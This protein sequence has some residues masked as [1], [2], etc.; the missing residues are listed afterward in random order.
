MNSR[1]KVLLANLGL[2]LLLY[3][4][5]R[6][7]FLALNFQSYIQ[8][9]LREL[10]LA[11][12][13]GGRF[14]IA[15]ICRINAPFI[16]LSLLPFGFVDKPWYR[17]LLKAVFLIA[18]IPFVLL[19]VVDY[20][21][22]KF[23]G[24]RSSLSLL[25]MGRDISDQIGQLAF[26]Y[27][28]LAAIGG[29]LVFALY[30]F[31]H[32][33]H[34]AP[35][36]KR[37]S[38]WAGDVLIFFLIVSLAVIGGRGGVQSRRLTPALAAVTDKESLT[39]LAL[40][41]TY[42]MINS[43]Q[44]CDGMRPVRYFSSD[45]ELA[46]QFP[47]RNPPVH[48]LTG[49]G[50]NIVIIIVESLSA[51]FT[52]IGNPGHGYTPFLDSLAKK[53]LY[54][55]NGF[56]NGRRSIDAPPSIL[57]GL[58]HLRDETFFC[59]EFK[60]LHGIGTIL[61]SR[62]YNTSFFHGGK[63]GTMFFDV[64]SRRMGFDDYYGLNEYPNPQD[65]DGIWGIYDEPY[66]QHFAQQLSRRPQPFASVL[67]TLS[68]HNPYQ[69][70][71]QYENTLP[72]GE[73]P[74]HRTVAYFDQA[75]KHFFTTAQT[76]PWY[77]NTLFVIVGDHIAPPQKIPPR[78]IDTYRVPIV[79]YYPG[80]ELPQVN[81][82]RIVQHVDIGPSLL[83]FAGIATEKILPFGHSIFDASYPGLALGQSGENFWIADAE[84]YL[85]YRQNG[86]GK[87]FATQKLDTP[88][89]DKADVQAQLESKLK[90]RIQWFN[91]GLVENRL[92]R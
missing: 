26:H 63:N 75:L 74:I 44:K 39:Q 9:P 2:L 60:T 54:F 4:I 15:A 22:F 79:F 37:S 77:K 53:G 69:I 34:S 13:V 83:D 48:K 73:L 55:K 21:Y 87:L 47:P 14:D 51:E 61:K 5:S 81:R 56:A 64:F 3:T 33:W 76:M 80:G 58:P 19:N 25:D 40:N 27:W 90:A 59:A 85:E 7:L 24:Q 50:K 42:T 91:N 18:N 31:S 16:V 92:Y 71:P 10:G 78:M 70:P 65:S 38:H 30:Y 62:G 35:L 57:A 46:K 23:T 84:Y 67:F 32:R 28:Y 8:L 49:A 52:G 29:A 66:L 17:G 43:Q 20:E 11:F 72:K 1:L 88:V 6:L 36:T 68:I 82:E 86:P 89:T 45:A 12:L 41:S